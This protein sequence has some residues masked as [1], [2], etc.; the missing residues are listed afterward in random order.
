MERQ[1]EI[2]RHRWQNNIKMDL[3]GVVCATDRSSDRWRALENAVKN[4]RCS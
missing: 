3:H 2:S 1:L 4:F